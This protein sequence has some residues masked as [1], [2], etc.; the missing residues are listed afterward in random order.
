MAKIVLITGGCRSGKSD[1]AL[2]KAKK[3]A[4]SRLFIATSPVTD[5]EMEDRIKKHKEVRGKQNWQTVEEE[6][7][8]IRELELNPDKSVILI[9]C[10]TLWINNLMYAAGCK[11]KTFGDDQVFKLC[12]NLMAVAGRCEGTVIIVTNE[13]GMGIVPEDRQTRMFRDLVGRANQTIAARS[14]E[15]YLVTCGIPVRIKP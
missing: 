15:V 4:G 11:K 12:D 13:V 8:I 14:D 6:I 2:Q 5:I 10:L 7:E 1:F 3:M 9:D